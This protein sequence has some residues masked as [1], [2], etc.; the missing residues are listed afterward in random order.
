[1]IQSQ[2]ML[3]TIEK[4]DLEDITIATLGSH[5][6]LQIFRGAKDEG[7]KTLAVCEKGREV[8]Y[9]RFGVADE[10]LLVDR[11]SDLLGRDVQEKLVKRNSIVVPHGSFVTHIGAREVMEDFK[12]PVFG[13]RGILLWESDRVMERQ[14]LERAGIRM[15]KEFNDPK[16]I[17]RLCFVKFPGAKG[18]RGYFIA[19][20]HEVFLEKVKYRLERG[21]ITE[22]DIKNATIQEYI[23][24]G[25]MYFSYFYSPLKDVVELVG[26]DRR[27]ESNIDG[28]TRIPALDQKD[29]Y[30]DP[31][32]E[33]SY[34]VVG[35]FPL[36]VRESV[37]PKVFEMGDRVVEVSKEIA[38]P[39]M[40]GPFCLETMVTGN[41]EII[42]FEISARIVAGTNPYGSG[43]PYTY[44]QTGEQVSMGR[45]IAR[46]IKEG[47]RRGRLKEL[48][49]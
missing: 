19:K 16:D 44:F 40:V 41:L 48:V 2:K 17:D 38:P 23:P 10:I 20:N 22:E 47:I 18:G 42:A 3:E 7:F 13:N 4:Y 12:V 37:L 45:R 33:P 1:M 30:D 34:V 27:Y 26:I 31:R 49:T 11:F 8:P 14:W 32:F 6:A 29:V 25:T 39:G 5:S 36:V 43:S 35:N 9:H 24:G 28:L 46:E 15:P 21:K